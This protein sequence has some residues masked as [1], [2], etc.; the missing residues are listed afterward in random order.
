MLQGG[1]GAAGRPLQELGWDQSAVGGGPPVE[2]SLG[3]GMPGRE[4]ALIEKP[5]DALAFEDDM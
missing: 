4:A 3:Q 1:Y 2:V 5:E